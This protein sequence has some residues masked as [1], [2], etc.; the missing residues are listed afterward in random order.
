M[1]KQAYKPPFLAIS[2]MKLILPARVLDAL[3]GD[4]LEEFLLRGQQDPASAKLWFWQQSLETSFIY[5]SKIF[6]SPAFIKK[7]N[8]IVPTLLF[9][10][11]F[12]LITWM[13]Y[14]DN[15]DEYSLEFWHIFVSGGYA[16]LLIFES[17][18]WLNILDHMTKIDG[19]NFLYHPPAVIITLC[20]FT[21]LYVLNKRPNFT[22]LNMACWGYSLML[23]PYIWSI[24]YISSHTFA[25]KQ[26]GPIIAI[27]I[28]S[29]LY[30]VL[31]VSYLVHRK[32][33]KSQ[34]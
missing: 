17:T 16:H 3:L 26:V 10:M 20:N 28:L 13:S 1:N 8:F 22:A 9:I 31:P 2:I 25:A 14:V 32:L 23:V 30:M 15:I 24:I 18:F 12:L 6:N 4:L 21:I 19:I 34:T 33:K 27:G 29:F 11:S 7:L 5:F